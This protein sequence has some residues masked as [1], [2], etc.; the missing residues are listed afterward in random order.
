MSVYDLF[1]MFGK[2]GTYF[3]DHTKDYCE[4]VVTLG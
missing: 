2:P 3:L 1:F 4:Y